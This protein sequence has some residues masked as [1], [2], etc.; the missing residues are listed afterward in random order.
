MS[1]RAGGGLRRND[2][3]LEGFFDEVEVFRFACR[4]SESGPATGICHDDVRRGLDDVEIT[5]IKRPFTEVDSV[6][7]AG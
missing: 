2:L 6:R 7:P 1:G 3:S 4:D 5:E